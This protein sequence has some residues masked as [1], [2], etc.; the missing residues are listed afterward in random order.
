MIKAW[1]DH[2][3][4]IMPSCKSC[5]DESIPMWT[6]KLTCP[7]WMHAPRKPYP[8]GNEQHTIFCSLTRQIIG[9]ELVEGKD[10]P[11]DRP[12]LEL[13]YDAKNNAFY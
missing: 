9:I 1:N 13:N 5:L 7:G 3:K 10:T 12:A 4:K 2:M 11:K 6:A 8:M